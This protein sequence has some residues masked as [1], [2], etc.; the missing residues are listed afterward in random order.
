MS[1][2]L[3]VTMHHVLVHAKMMLMLSQSVTARI[4][5]QRIHAIEYAH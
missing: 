2:A 3:A 4:F 1:H 5:C